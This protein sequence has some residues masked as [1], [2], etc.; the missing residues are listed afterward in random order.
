PREGPMAHS[1]HIAD[2]T[3]KTFQS[4]VVER[5]RTTP[6]VID[7][8]ATWCGPCRTLGPLLE[9]LAIEGKGRFFLAKVDVDQNPEL[10]RTFQVQSIPMVLAIAGGRLVDG[11]TGAQP[12]KFVR[13]FIDHLAPPSK[14]DT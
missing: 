5:S 9:K 3:A 6:V 10:A 2:V 8:W 4:E 7:F 13:E 14:D 1:P 11:F 12:E